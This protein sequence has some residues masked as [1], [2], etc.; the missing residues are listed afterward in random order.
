MTEYG[1]GN[2]ITPLTAYWPLG[3]LN[4][5]LDMPFFTTDFSDWWQ[6]PLDVTDYQSTL[7][8][9]TAWCRQA[10]S[11]YLSQCWPRSL[12]PYGSVSHNELIGLKRIDRET[13]LNTTYVVCYIVE[14]KVK[15]VTVRHWTWRE[16]NRSAP[17]M[18]NIYWVPLI[19]E[20]MKTNN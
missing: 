15:T 8:Q 5:I 10:T 6:M 11:H 9:A 13:T 1:S 7:V 20:V 12:S 18:I 16:N 19:R 3:N 14:V 2:K 4:E 17:D